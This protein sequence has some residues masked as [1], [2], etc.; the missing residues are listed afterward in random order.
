MPDLQVQVR[1]RDIIVSKP[2]LGLS[3]T[4]RKAANGPMLEA[5]DPIRGRL[6][7]E[8][9]S[10]LVRAWKAAYERA[11]SLGWLN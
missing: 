5:L 3:L 10:F 2:S 4:Y 11:Q 1:E 6:S 8:E 7:T 9:L